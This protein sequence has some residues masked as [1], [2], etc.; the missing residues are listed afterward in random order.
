MTW[1]WQKE[2]G[3]KSPSTFTGALEAGELMA[4]RTVSKIVSVGS[5]PTRPVSE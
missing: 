2:I 4:M 5:T 1:P 3:G